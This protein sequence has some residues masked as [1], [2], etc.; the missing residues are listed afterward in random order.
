MEKPTP[1]VNSAQ[2]PSH[3]GQTVRLVGKVISFTGDIGV[4]ESSDKGQ[5]KE[6]LRWGAP[7][8]E[9]IGRVGPD[10]VIE[11]FTSTDFGQSLDLDL[12]DKVAVLSHTFPD[13]FQ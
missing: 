10:L 8:V 12:A 5:V 11:E 7:Y 13:I 3:V 1:R 9:V 4:L 2:L 6:N